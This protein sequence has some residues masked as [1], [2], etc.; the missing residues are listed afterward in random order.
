VGW[1]LLNS[2]EGQAQLANLDGG[3]DRVKV[4]KSLDN[5]EFVRENA[6]KMNFASKDSD[7][8]HLEDFSKAIM[9]ID[10]LPMDGIHVQTLYP[11]K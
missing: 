2:D 4:S 5:L 7:I 1:F 3:A 9:I 10:K 6:F 8:T 11:V